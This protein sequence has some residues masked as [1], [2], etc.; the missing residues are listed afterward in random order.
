MKYYG[1]VNPHDC[2]MSF[3]KFERLPTVVVFEKKNLARQGQINLSKYEW[4]S[5]WVTKLNG[6]SADSGQRGP[7]GPYKLC[8]RSLYIGF[9]ILP[10]IY[11][12]QSTGHKF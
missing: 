4:V 7:Y 9:I 5:E 12:T 1:S 11:N 10:L 6:L 8:N 3:E 2:D